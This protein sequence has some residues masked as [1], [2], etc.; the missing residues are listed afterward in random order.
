MRRKKVK[1]LRNRKT[2][3][4]APNIRNARGP[5]HSHTSHIFCDGSCAP[6]PGP[7]ASACVI[8]DE[9]KLLE[10]RHGKFDPEGTNNSAELEA[11]RLAFDLVNELGL[12]DT[13]VI[14]DSKYA[15]ESI[16]RAVK[17]SINKKVKQCPNVDLILATYRSFAGVKDRVSL[18]LV[19]SHK[20]IE[21]NEIAD[22]AC[23]LARR[24]KVHDLQS[25][26]R[27]LI[28]ASRPRA[29]L[30]PSILESVLGSGR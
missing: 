24:K 26:P 9:R 25:L 8:Y 4:L 17:W 22:L 6:N 14:S 1:Q 27:E 29:R 10:V 28:Q 11:L 2:R 18:S 20:G 15:L 30:K 16:R 21:G 19:P 23:N 3:E 13:E 5:S 12:T 7:A